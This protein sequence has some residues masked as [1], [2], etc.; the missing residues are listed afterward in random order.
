[1]EGWKGRRE[2]TSLSSLSSNV[3]TWERSVCD[4]LYLNLSVLEGVCLCVYSW[5]SHVPECKWL[6]H[7]LC[8]LMTGGLVITGGKS[9]QITQNYCVRLPTLHA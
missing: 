3:F 7:R 2:E 6:F 9:Q 8:S 5:N 4:N 1:M